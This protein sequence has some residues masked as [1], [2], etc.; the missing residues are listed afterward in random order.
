MEKKISGGKKSGTPSQRTSV[1][2]SSDR[3]GLTLEVAEQTRRRRQLYE[4]IALASTFVFIGAVCLIAWQTDGAIFQSPISALQSLGGSEYQQSRNALI[5]CKDPRNTNTPYCQERIAKMN[6]KWTEM[7]KVH[8][9]RVS[10]FTLHEKGERA[11][12]APNQ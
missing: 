8:G 4:R 2:K 7:N 6:A 9:G 11:R 3:A 5:N 12:Y 10:P 1:S